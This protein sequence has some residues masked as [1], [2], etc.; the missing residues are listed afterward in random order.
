MPT[1]NRMPEPNHN[2][3]RVAP[4]MAIRSD[5]PYFNAQYRSKSGTSVGQGQH[6]RLFESFHH[7]CHKKSDDVLGGNKMTNGKA[8]YPVADD[9]SHL[10]PGIKK[11]KA[12]WPPNK[13]ITLHQTRVRKSFSGTP[14]DGTVISYSPNDK[15]YAVKYDDS[16]VEEYSEDELL[17]FVA[18]HPD[19]SQLL[20]K[21]PPPAAA[22]TSTR[23]N[24]LRL[25]KKVGRK[26]KWEEGPIFRAKVMTDRG[27]E[28]G[29]SDG[30]DEERES[31]NQKKSAAVRSMSNVPAGY[32]RK[33]THQ[34][35][36]ENDE[37]SEYKSKASDVIA[38][39][40]KKAKMKPKASASSTEEKAADAEIDRLLKEAISEC[41]SCRGFWLR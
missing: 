16:E 39:K 19:H 17:E 14:Y 23:N 25:A 6:N 28:H 24:P 15:W 20:R 4:A 7:H 40:K 41:Q 29:G 13:R 33:R 37:D 22:S 21:K 30:S 2:S 1:T 3:K 18:A 26:K 9:D 10:S 11:T 32:A 8:S 27:T 38:A 34:S 12:A 36:S 31:K 35:D 5:V